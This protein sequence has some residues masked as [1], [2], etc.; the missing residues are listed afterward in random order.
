MHESES[1]FDLSNVSRE[2]NH[3]LATYVAMIEKWNRS[4]NLI[5]TTTEAIIWTRHIHDSAQLFAYR[6]TDEDH[7]VD[8]G[9]G[10]GLPAVVLAI[11]A[12]GMNLSMRFTL[13]E[14]D[15][16]KAVFLTQVTRE[17]D[18][19]VTTICARIEDTEPLMADVVS[20]RAV[21]A[22]DQLC[23]WSHPHLAQK[24]RAVFPKGAKFSDE[25][26]NARIRWVF[27]L[28]EFPSATDPD[29]KVLILE[30]IRHA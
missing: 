27:D 13:V 8:F 5:S 2:T 12:R 14:S 17:L 4:I 22:L 10:G 19:P 30:N 3:M 28:S 6:K 24:G 26:D 1:P 29:A 11:L 21:A 25:I 9:S 16:R 18:L 7:W 15:R 20:A 23:A